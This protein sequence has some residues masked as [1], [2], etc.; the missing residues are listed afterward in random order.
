MN[1]AGVTVVNVGTNG[2]EV[3]ERR[4]LGEERRQ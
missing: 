1:G 4:E 3:E 2:S